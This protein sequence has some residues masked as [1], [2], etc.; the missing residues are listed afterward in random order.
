MSRHGTVLINGME[1]SL[2]SDFS[3][4]YHWIDTSAGELLVPEGII[5][6]VVSA[7]VLKWFIRYIYYW[8]LHFLNNVIINKNDGPPS[9]VM[10]DRC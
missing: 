5:H 2:S 8:D 3:K 4:V 1:I 10:A 6:P 7:L 9:S